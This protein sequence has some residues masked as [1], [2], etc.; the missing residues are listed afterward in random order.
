[1]YTPEGQ[2]R[3]MLADW[4]G[5]HAACVRSS[6]GEGIEDS[7]SSTPSTVIGPRRWPSL[8]TDTHQSKRAVAL[9]E[10]LTKLDK[11]VAGGE[12][13]SVLNAQSRSE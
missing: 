10:R 13:T 7:S 11:A 4:S 1:M 2:R 3:W 5:V 12:P 9:E 6:A 8:R